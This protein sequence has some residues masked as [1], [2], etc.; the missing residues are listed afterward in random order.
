[1]LV[2]VEEINIINEIYSF[3]VVFNKFL[4]NVMK[5]IYLIKIVIFEYF[6]LVNGDLLKFY[7]FYKKV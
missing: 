1:M 6:V 4:E 3:I 5:K 7:V 2:F